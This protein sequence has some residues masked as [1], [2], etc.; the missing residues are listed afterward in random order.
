MAGGLELVG[1][2]EGSDSVHEKSTQAYGKKEEHHANP[3]NVFARAEREAGR[4]FAAAHFGGIP[5]S[6]SGV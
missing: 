6:K 1:A 3:P 4:G 5:S 2:C